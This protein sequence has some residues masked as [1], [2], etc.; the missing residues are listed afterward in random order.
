ML[1]HTLTY[2]KLYTCVILAPQLIKSNDYKINIMSL[3][4]KSLQ[5]AMLLKESKDMLRRRILMAY[6][7][8][9]LLLIEVSYIM[10]YYEPNFYSKIASKIAY[11]ICAY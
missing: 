3:Y 4:G 2:N 1:V 10:I 5:Q 9:L 7:L 6:L 8:K 11:L